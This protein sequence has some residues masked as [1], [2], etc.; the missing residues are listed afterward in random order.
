MEEIQQIVI[1]TLSKAKISCT[2]SYPIGAKPISSALASTVQLPELGL[3]FYAG[4]GAGLL[5]GQYQFLRVGYL[6][7]ARPIEFWHNLPP[8]GRWEIVVRP[9]PPVLRHRFKQYIVETALPQI[10][11]WLGERTQLAQQG[12]DTLAF[13]Y[14]E[15]T[16]EFTSRQSTH[17]EPLRY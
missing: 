5:R 10:A 1:P 2:L 9:V 17:L 15:K 7:K 3:H 6:N 13:F 11:H 4:F 12:S 8:Q 16:E 14:N